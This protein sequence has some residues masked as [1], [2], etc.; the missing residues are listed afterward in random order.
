MYPASLTQHSKLHY[1]R[2]ASRQDVEAPQEHLFQSCNDNL[3][4]GTS[5]THWNS[6]STLDF[7][8]EQSPSHISSK[9]TQ[10]RKRHTKPKQSPPRFNPYPP[11]R[12]PSSSYQYGTLLNDD[13]SSANR[14]VTP[15]LT[16]TGSTVD[17]F[18]ATYSRSQPRRRTPEWRSSYPAQLYSCYQYQDAR[19]HDGD[20]L[21]SSVQEF[22]VPPTIRPAILER[23]D[24]DYDSCNPSPTY[25]HEVIVDIVAH[26]MREVRGGDDLQQCPVLHQLLT[27]ILLAGKPWEEGALL[28]ECRY[29]SLI[30]EKEA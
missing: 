11:T 15:D 5:F 29:G 13:D 10:H 22:S 16:T 2:T 27:M 3:P 24:D 23:R 17:G 9:Q 30:M 18:P 14:P 25:L 4:N 21:F 1:F 12:P 19:P 6:F 28:G 20:Q 26:I 7:N 8:E